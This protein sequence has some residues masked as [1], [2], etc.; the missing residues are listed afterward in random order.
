MSAPARIG[1]LL[2]SRDSSGVLVAPDGAIL[3]RVS[4][5]NAGAVSDGVEGLVAMTAQLHRKA[6]RLGAS[7]VSV[8]VGFPGVIDPA[9]GTIRGTRFA[10][11]AWRGTS[12]AADLTQRLDLPVT[13]RNDVVCALLG[14]A[15]VGAAVG[16]QNVVLAYS[17]NGVGGAIMLDGQI[18]LGRRGT[19]GHLGHV[20]CEA[21]A[22]LRCSCGGLGHLDSV[23]S[24]AGM[25]TWYRR[26]VRLD[27]SG[28]PYLRV[29]TDAAAAGN[30]TAIATLQRGGTALG[31]AL[32]GVSNLLEPDVMVLAGESAA[33]SIYTAA[34][35]TALNAEIIPGGEAPEIRMSVLRGDAQVVGAALSS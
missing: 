33:D 13:V 29:V 23:A 21:A 24:A 11:R 32:G 28:A 30:A 20:P 31:K 25:T 9:D 34:V 4:V 26:Q 7:P 27:P 8:G 2:G 3:A 14:E 10:M 19:A 12:L 5:P 17:S 16:E 18:V 1:L 15:A 6:D 22:G 35:I